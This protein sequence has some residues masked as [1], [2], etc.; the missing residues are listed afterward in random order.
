[1]GLYENDIIQIGVKTECRANLARLAIFYGNKTNLPFLNF[2]P[3]VTTSPVLG[4]SL[5]LQV[6]EVDSTVEAGAQFQQMVNVECVTDFAE[7]PDLKLT[8]Y[9]TG[10]M[11]HVDIKLPISVNKFIEP[12]DMNGEA[13]FS[14]WKNLSIPSQESQKIFK[15]AYP[16][17]NTEAIKTKLIGYGFQLL[18]EGIDP[19]PDN[20]VCAGIIHTR[21]VQIGV[22]LR[23]EP[24]KQAEMYRLTTRSSKESV[25]QHISS[26]LCE[27]F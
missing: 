22:L 13:F 6:K 25:S 18:E 5:L 9:Y 16:M 19:N 23:L 14:R 24:N 27:Q 15:A 3:K 2:Q 20:F 10:E 12:T 26:I 21:A 11:R 17:E 8:F 1:M 7:Q 4:M